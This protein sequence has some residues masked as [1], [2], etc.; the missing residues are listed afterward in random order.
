L[1]LEAGTLTHCR[2]GL[3]LM[4]PQAWAVL[5]LLARNAGRV[6]TKAQML[7][8]VWPGLVVT[9]ASLAKAV[10]DVRA[11]LGEEGRALIKTVARRGYLLANG[12]STVPITWD[13]DARLVS[14]PLAPPANSTRLLGRE[15]EL[16][17]LRRMLLEHRLVTVLGSGGVGKTVF[18]RA[19]VHEYGKDGS[20]RVAWVNLAPIADPSLLPAT[21]ARALGL[22]ISQGEDP[23]AG[24]L[25][26]LRSRNCLLVLDNAEHLVDMI[27]Q[28][29]ASIL[30]AAPSMNL[31]VTSQVPLHLEAERMFRLNPLDV[32]H[33]DEPL[34]QARLA[35][36][37]ALFE[38]RA[39][40]VDRE[41]VLTEDNVRTVV[42]ICRRL[43]GVPL[44]IRLAA[45]RARVLG[46]SALEAHLDDRL[47]WLAS[48]HR[49]S[50]G[51]QRT[52][53]DALQWSYG[54]LNAAEQQLFRQLGAFVGGFT[55]ELAIAMARAA[56]ADDARTV[57]LLDGLVERSLID[58]EPG[59][60]PRFRMLESQHALALLEL[61]KLGELHETRHHHA[62]IFAAAADGPPA[63]KWAIPDTVWM[64]RSL[65]EL[66]NLRAALRW[67]EQNSPALFASLTW[68]ATG[69]YVLLDIGHELSRQADAI[70]ASAIGELDAG[71]ASR[72][73]LARTFLEQR[74]GSRRLKHATLAEH[75]ARKSGDPLFLYLALCVK[76]ESAPTHTRDAAALI[77][78]ISSLESPDW[79]PRVR[80]FRW[81]ALCTLE[82]R[83]ERWPQA[84]EAA[85]AGLA[86]TIQAGATVLK[87]L[88][89]NAVLVAWIGAG[90]LDA[91]LNRSDA[92]RQHVLPG[93]ANAVIPY[94]GT[95][96]RL[97]LLRGDLAAARTHLAE[98]FELCRAVEW[99]HFES[100][101][102]VY[103]H[104]ALMERRLESAARLVGY[105]EQ[106]TG[107]LWA[108][109]RF[110]SLCNAARA[111]LAEE[112]DPLHLDALFEQGAMLGPEAVCRTTLA[113]D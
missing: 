18:A 33:A 74:S 103:F 30:E 28:V 104:L 71:L 31:L 19:A 93:P 43:N 82:I 10:S 50:P 110:E 17:L 107:T 39:I 59:D 57:A 56:D 3:V 112:I 78:E 7:D 46:L 44:A 12:H 38:D 87:S 62:R 63:T 79:P 21:L 65:P 61:A 75:Y 41:F 52:L 1:D 69:M 47:V 101:S 98:M 68:A 9:E 94:I 23:L 8:A 37:V 32:P 105:A 58:R 22:P 2:T 96:A 25:G 66:D 89:C 5:E 88:F 45:G 95:R 85:E 64:P 24:L 34:P 72:F 100:F 86:L 92:L 26:A 35:G 60:P 84:L 51:R 113:H 81:Q 54:L 77:R 40:A 6:V 73:H 80:F 55:L 99:S 20:H 29:A 70:D 4:R 83:A 27:A 111:Q 90:D 108:L 67:G 106:A 13:T 53:L 97:Q 11:A 76:L 16:G 91:A 109:L 48:E 102:P 36:A 14:N 15:Q 49:D 42:R